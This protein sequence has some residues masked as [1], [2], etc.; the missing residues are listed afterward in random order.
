MSPVTALVAVIGDQRADHATGNE[1]PKD[2]RRVIVGAGRR[3]H[4]GAKGKRARRQKRGEFREHQIVLSL[5][6][7]LPAIAVAMIGVVAAVA[8]AIGARPMRAVR[9][10]TMR[11]MRPVRA[12][13]M[14][15]M[16]TVARRV[17]ATVVTRSVMAGLI[18]VSARDMAL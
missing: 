15:L 6:R 4:P 14:T 7:Y 16:R 9:A 8:V 13:G 3:G 11:P 17:V 18:T 2:F 1:S 5:F 12:I 10:I